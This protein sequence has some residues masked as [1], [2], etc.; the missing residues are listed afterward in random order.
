MNIFD[1]IGNATLAL[2]QLPLLMV[3]VVKKLLAVLL[4]KR[5][6]APKPQEVEQELNRR[7]QAEGPPRKIDDLQSRIQALQRRALSNPTPGQDLLQRNA[8][9]ALGSQRTPSVAAGAQ[10]QH[11]SARSASE[12]L[13]KDGW[14]RLTTYP[15]FKTSNTIV[16]LHNT[17][18][19]IAKDL[20]LEQL[21]VELRKHGF[22]V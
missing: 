17:K 9:A 10:N 7:I 6:A 21:K 13:K 5:K 8:N 14:D 3:G 1:A 18:E 16:R 15:D 19:N 12:V 11:P 20:T 22:T 2:A 4:K